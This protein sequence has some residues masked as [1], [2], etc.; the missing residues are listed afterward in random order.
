M[1]IIGHRGGSHT[2][3]ENTLASV[4]AALDADVGFEVDLQLLR[5][6][7]MVVLHDNTL[8]RTVAP[9]DASVLHK[10][11]VKAPI[12]TL[13]WCEIRDLDVGSWFAPQYSCERIPLF[14]DVLLELRRAAL[15]PGNAGAHCFAELKGD[16]PHDPMLPG[17]A[18]AAVAELRVPPDRLTWISFSLPLLIEMKALCPGYPCLYI[19]NAETPEAAWRAARASIGARL[20]GVDLRCD[21]KVVTAE[22]CAWMH[23]CGKRVAV[24]V[25]C[26][27]APEDTPATWEA[28]EQSGVDDLTSNLPP[29]LYAWRDAQAKADDA[30]TAGATAL[31]VSAGYALSR[32]LTPN[33]RMAEDL[34]DLV[35]SLL[36][37]ACSLRAIGTPCLTARAAWPLDW[38]PPP[39]RETAAGAAN[40]ADDDDSA[41][42]CRAAAVVPFLPPA[43]DERAR[44]F[45]LCSSTYFACDVALIL[46]S[47]ARGVRPH[48]WAGRLAHHIIQF[49]A[50]A[51]A[52]MRSPSAAVVRRYLLAAYVAEV[53][54]TL[55]RIKGLA[56]AAGLGG[57]RA[58]THLQRL[59]LVSFVLS[60][61]V[62]FP[63]CT[64][65]V[66]RAR[67][68]VPP[69]IWRLHLAFAAGG[70]ALS[71][72]W[73]LQ[74]ARK[75]V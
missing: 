64:H 30:R 56:R 20:D 28:L 33:A 3:P 55:L 35:H 1:R 73:F 52:L 24:W 6:G 51:P 74:L 15:R 31:G 69:L 27:P 46:A 26:A 4:R 43:A 2:T 61:L 22:L 71:T 62:N 42:L 68:A 39:R 60:R 41:R 75:G 13:R 58:H 40:G 21:P 29:S 16:R 54:T 38:D 50:N 5:D 37:T 63:L 23:A 34:V 70:I 9:P 47:L 18:A 49:V 59:L 45:V 19:A 17:A 48:L 66:Y 44:H 36:A 8:E 12:T 14:R 11:L 72:G 32:A 53:S 57:P 10:K 67:A 7:T 25:S 65:A